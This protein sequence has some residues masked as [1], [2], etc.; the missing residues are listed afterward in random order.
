MK[1]DWIA[2]YRGGE[3]RLDVVLRYGT[4]DEYPRRDYAI[5]PHYG[6]VAYSSIIEVRSDT[7]RAQE[8]E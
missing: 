4:D 8:G 7:L 6:K 3:V 2:F 5:T 1:Q